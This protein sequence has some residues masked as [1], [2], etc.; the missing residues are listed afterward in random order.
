[1]MSFGK[2]GIEVARVCYRP[3]HQKKSGMSE[4]GMTAA[5]VRSVFP[6]P[7]LDP[8]TKR[9]TKRNNPWKL[10]V[11]PERGHKSGSV[12]HPVAHLYLARIRVVE[13]SAPDH[14]RLSSDKDSTISVLE[15]P[16]KVESTSKLSSTSSSCRY[17]AHPASCHV[18]MQVRFHAADADDAGSGASYS[19]MGGEEHRFRCVRL[20]AFRAFGFHS[21]SR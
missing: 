7:D 4:P 20:F 14:S 16:E 10:S 2:M 17:V 18:K 9:Y 8:L 6:L 11:A 21:R 19:V 13:I 1:M 3:E 5:V 12:Q 15:Q